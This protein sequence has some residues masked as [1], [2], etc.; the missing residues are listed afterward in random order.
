MRLVQLSYRCQYFISWLYH[1][2]LKVVLFISLTGFHGLPCLI[3]L[4]FVNA[5]HSNVA[6]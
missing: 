6:K 5:F 3:H 1:I 4:N 2:F